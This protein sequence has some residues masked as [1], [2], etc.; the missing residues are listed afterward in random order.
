M[1]A[2]G[3]ELHGRASWALAGTATALE[4]RLF[5]YTAGKGT[6]EVGV[7]AVRRLEKPAAEGASDFAFRLPALPFSFSG[8]LITLTWAVEFVVLPGDRA[9]RAEFVLSPHGHEL[10]LPATAPPA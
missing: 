8:K 4:I 2:P 6:V 3:G 1:F 10:V 5:W 7:V 9:A